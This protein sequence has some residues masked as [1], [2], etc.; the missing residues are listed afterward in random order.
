MNLQFGTGKT[1]MVDNQEAHGSA[2]SRY[3]RVTRRPE[4]QRQFPGEYAT[5]H[6]LMVEATHEEAHDWANGYFLTDEIVKVELWPSVPVSPNAEVSDR[7]PAASASRET[8][9]GGS[10]H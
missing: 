1:G 6:I 2:K 4:N 7:R 5:R 10:L 9:N 8:H 3:W